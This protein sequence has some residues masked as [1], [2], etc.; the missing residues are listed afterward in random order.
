V[1]KNLLTICRPEAS[2]IGAQ[3]C[4]AIRGGNAM[5]MT[6]NNSATDDT[7]SEMNTTPLIDVML[8]LLTLLIITLPMQTNAVKL[9]LPHGVPPV[10]EKPVVVNLAIDF[11][12]TISWNGQQI[13][14]A[15]LN[16]NLIRAA[17]QARQ[18]ELHI[19]ADRLAKYDTVA[20]VLTDA[21]RLGMTKIGFANTQQYGN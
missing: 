20:K 6:L 12:G 4:P 10:A 2:T 21:Q 16:A 5:A 17:H 19:Q 13:S 9:T 7:M 8:V 11:D 14:E 3:R 1:E 18:P 15:Q